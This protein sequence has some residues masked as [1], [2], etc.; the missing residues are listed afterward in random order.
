MGQDNKFG[1]NIE[2]QSIKKLSEKSY[3]ES[4]QEIKKYD[5]NK[6]NTEKPVTGPIVMPGSLDRIKPVKTENSQT[7]SVSNGDVTFTNIETGKIQNFAKTQVNNLRIESLYKQAQDVNEN[8]KK[9]DNNFNSSIVGNKDDE[10][11]NLPIEQEIRNFSY[12]IGE[13]KKNSFFIILIIIISIIILLLFGLIFHFILSKKENKKTI[14]NI[15][16]CSLNIDEGKNQINSNI[17]YYFND[18]EVSK[19]KETITNTFT[20]SEAYKNHMLEYSTSSLEKISGISI[21]NSFNTEKNQHVIIYQYDYDVLNNNNN[22]DI[23]KED[24]KLTI[25]K[26]DDMK[27]L[28]VGSL[29]EIMTLVEANGYICK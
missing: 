27:E 17:I 2:P 15:L 19:E 20:D 11:L 6:I 4:Y 21:D 26:D 25:T 13:H 23:L 7:Y 18:G 28:F 9:F 16:S 24:N 10:K 1:S 14:E 29:K 12:P 22:S 5:D 8:V 3:Q